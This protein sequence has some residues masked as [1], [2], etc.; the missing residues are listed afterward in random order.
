[1]ADEKYS[2]MARTISKQPIQRFRNVTKNSDEY[3]LLCCNKDIVS[4]DANLDIQKKM[5][6]IIA[7]LKI[8][9]NPDA[10]LD[11]MTDLKDQNIILI[12]CNITSNQNSSAK[13]D[14]L[15][16]FKQIYKGNIAQENIIEQLEHDYK[17]ED[18]IKWYT[19][20]TFLF[21]TLNQALRN[22]DF[23]VIFAL[24][25]FINDLHKNLVNAHQT[26]LTLHTPENPV[27]HVYRGQNIS[28]S[29]LNFL[30]QNIGQ[31]VTM[32]SFLSTS[33]DR[34]IAKFFL[35]AAAPSTV[36]TATILFEFHLDKRISNTKSYANIK[37]LSYFHDEEEVLIML[38]SIFRINQIEYNDEEN[39]WIGILTLCTD[40]DYELQE[41]MKH[42]KKEIG[43]GIT[44][45]GILLHR[46]GNYEKAGEYFQQ[47]LS[48]PLLSDLDRSRC[49]RGLAMVANALLKHDEALENYQK[50]IELLKNSNEDEEIGSAYTFI[51]EVYLFKKDL[52]S[53]LSYEQ[54]AL[55]ILLPLRAPQLSNIK[56]IILRVGVGV[57]DGVIVFLRVWVWVWVWVVWVWVWVGVGVGVGKAEG[58]AHT[59]R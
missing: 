28:V 20:P 32:Q 45:P 50:Q 38:G 12:L 30:R 36:D 9:D 5:R 41:L 39:I 42:L 34:T 55:D 25:F 23:D 54:K 18:A 4:S 56:I 47:I 24:R 57:G 21:S 44:S 1:M 35:G 33:F 7:D 19:R 15:E 22:S 2:E 14:L 53:A 8:F 16:H 31:F 17:S 11:Y 37:E 40:D 48:D 26:F 46:Q 51:G 10:C 52:D 59:L 27:I 43:E 58:H 29:D 6:Q 13:Q 3:V 49:Y